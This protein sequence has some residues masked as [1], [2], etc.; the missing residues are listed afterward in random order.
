MYQQRFTSR[1]VVLVLILACL[2]L[3]SASANDCDI[4]ANVFNTNTTNCCELNTDSTLILCDT[5][6]NVISI[7][8]NALNTS[9][10]PDHSQPP[11]TC[12]INSN[13]SMLTHLQSL[14]L[15]NFVVAASSACPQ[16]PDWIGKLTNLQYLNLQNNLLQESYFNMSTTW[17]NLTHL[18]KLVLADNSFQTMPN[19]LSNIPSLTSLDISLNSINS[20]YITGSNLPNLQHLNVSLHFS[21]PPTFL[22]TFTSLKSLNVDFKVAFVPCNSASVFDLCSSLDSSFLQ[23]ISRMNWLQSLAVQMDPSIS[24]SPFPSWIQNFTVLSSLT[25][26]ECSLNGSIPNYLGNLNLSYIDLSANILDGT[27]PASIYNPNLQ[28]LYLTDNQL[29]GELP[30]TLYN[31]PNCNLGVNLGIICPTLASS[32]ALCVRCKVQLSFISNTFSQ[33]AHILIID[34]LIFGL[35]FLGYLFILVRRRRSFPLSFFYVFLTYFHIINL[36]ACIFV[37]AIRLQLAN[38]LLIA[39]ALGCS[40]AWNLNATRAQIRPADVLPSRGIPFRIVRGLSYLDL[41]NLFLFSYQPLFPNSN[42]F[43]TTRR[44]IAYTTP[45][46]LL[47]NLLPLVIASIQLNVWIEGI[48][49]L[50]AI[51]SAI[52]IVRFIAQIVAAIMWGREQEARA[53]RIAEGIKLENRESS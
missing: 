22:S 6:S 24:P 15:V 10:S 53:Q 11:L 39:L 16:W 49:L 17:N 2:F 20:S 3:V 52:S 7:M 42:F 40:I 25:L 26:N 27:I 4:V 33:I 21:T 51:V 28:S 38:C 14:T 50:T 47:S 36:A 9:L 41:N 35:I 48:F 19:F 44:M 30:K 34:S 32:P 5:N 18:D 23:P 37:F 46:V 43:I 8:Y 31:I 13:I 12:S 29:V 45:Q 1:W